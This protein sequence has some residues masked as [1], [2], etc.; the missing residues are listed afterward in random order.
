MNYKDIQ[1]IYDSVIF[2]EVEGNGKDLILGKVGF[3]YMLFFEIKIGNKY[4]KIVILLILGG[5]N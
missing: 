4:D 5:E 1:E 3:I 2:E